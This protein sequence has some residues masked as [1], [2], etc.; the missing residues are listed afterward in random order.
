M[1][2]KGRRDKDRRGDFMGVEEGVKGIQEK[3]AT[4]PSAA[5]VPSLSAA[6]FIFP[7]H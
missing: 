4:E 1:E 7:P 3:P 5:R 6:F 2:I